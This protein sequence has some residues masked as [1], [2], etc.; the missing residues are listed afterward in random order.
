MLISGIGYVVLFWLIG[1]F[2]D[3]GTKSSA[4]VGSTVPPVK[5]WWRSPQTAG[6]VGALV[7]IAT[8]VLLARHTVTPAPL[9]ASLAGFPDTIGRWSAQ[10]G[11]EA[12]PGWRT[13][14]FDDNLA[15]TYALPDGST[16]DLFL[17]YF[18]SQ[19]PGREL[20]GFEVS[21]LL[22]SE[23]ERWTAAAAVDAR[24]AVTTVNSQRSHV[25]YWYVINGRALS[26][27]VLAKCLLTWSALTSGKT[28]GAI[29]VAR[30]KLRTPTESTDSVRSRIADFIAGVAS[31]T[32]VYLPA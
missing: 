2:Q 4:S 27:P 10:V 24:D 1:R 5:T 17:G 23:T 7:L 32:Q 31:A 12:G 29:I 11:D 25:T 21:R 18:E 28:N 22:P 19:S 8:A 20:V 9:Q 15:R 14:R 13:I 26:N 3:R 30:T 16:V 6:A